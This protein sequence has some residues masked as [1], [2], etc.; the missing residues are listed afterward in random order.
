LNE[1][2]IGLLFAFRETILISLGQPEKFDELFPKNHTPFP[3]RSAQWPKED[4]LL[5]KHSSLFP[6]NNLF[7]NI[8][9]IL[10]EYRNP[11]CP[12]RSTQCPKENLLLPK[13]PTLF[14]KNNLLGNIYDLLEEYRYFLTNIFTSHPVKPV[15]WVIFVLYA[16]K[17]TSACSCIGEKLQFQIV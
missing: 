16:G 5:P 8:Y 3:K 13:R 7:E 15:H 17:A 4:P 14:P 6:K 9:D 10:R 1:T 2:T 12:K 11:L